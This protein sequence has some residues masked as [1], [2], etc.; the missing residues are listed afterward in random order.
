[1]SRFQ[2]KIWQK[3][4][5]N[6]GYISPASW[7]C[8]CDVQL[9]EVR[10]MWKDF[11]VWKRSENPQREKPQEFWSRKAGYFERVSSCDNSILSISQVWSMQCKVRWWRWTGTARWSTTSSIIE[12]LCLWRWTFL[13]P[14]LKIAT[15]S[16]QASKCLSNSCDSIQVLHWFKQ[17]LIG[18]LGRGCLHLFNFWNSCNFSC[19]TPPSLK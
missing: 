13:G 12:V 19:V 9:C 2:P 4:K 11:H 16:W 17:W 8:S 5:K 7:I 15:L 3:I 10:P 14:L 6:C 18:L 1:M